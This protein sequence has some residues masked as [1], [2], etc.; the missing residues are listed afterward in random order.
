MVILRIWDGASQGYKEILALVGPKGD[1]RDKG[2]TGDTGS[3]GPTGP[4]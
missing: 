1:K 3:Q 2:D 4:V